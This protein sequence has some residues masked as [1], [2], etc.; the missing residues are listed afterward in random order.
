MLISN[1][2][3]C[4]FETG[5][6]QLTLQLDWSHV[7]NLMQATDVY[8]FGVLLWEMLTSTRAWA[9]LRHAQIMCQV[10][11]YQLHAVHM[12]QFGIV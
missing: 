10:L 9:G 7:L 3:G 11:P 2:P 4:Y 12:I 1:Q 5:L 8:S 6:M